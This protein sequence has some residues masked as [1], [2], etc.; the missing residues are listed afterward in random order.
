V[1]ARSIPPLCPLEV[2]TM[3]TLH[4][5][6]NVTVDVDRTSSCS[7]NLKSQELA[8]V[9]KN[10]SINFDDIL[11]LT[12]LPLALVGVGITETRRIALHAPALVSTKNISKWKDSPQA[13]KEVNDEVNRLLAEMEATNPF[14]EEADAQLAA[15]LKMDAVSSSI[16]FIVRAAITSAW[17][18]FECL[19]KDLWVVSLNSR[20]INLAHRTFR[21]VTDDSPF[22]GLSGKS[23]S[24]GLLA[25]EGFDLRSCLG[26]LL[27]SKFDFTGVSG[28]REAYFAA[29]ERSETLKTI[30]VNAEL[31]RLEAIRHLVVHRAGI[32]DAEF[33][34]RVQT[35]VAEGE[36]LALD[37]Q[38]VSTLS[39][40]AIHAGCDLLEFVDKW[41][42]SN[43]A[44]VPKRLQ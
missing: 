3:T 33:K 13:K 18:A 9:A 39:N 42:L 20:P 14:I 32:I 2:F 1:R 15:L 25:R 31:D 41:L 26:T 35:N 40:T 28:I 11:G 16:R 4:L 34:R 37:G 6:S 5:L 22:D 38:A 43:P 44:A 24:V 8:K 12:A 30:F 36:L 19:A 27:S 21:S 10:F 23:I 29:F 17:T 7:A